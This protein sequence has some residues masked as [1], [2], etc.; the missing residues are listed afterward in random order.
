[1]SVQG[2][3]SIEEVAA[4]FKSQAA[5][6]DVLVAA[7]NMR[8]EH[9]A[10]VAAEAE[11]KVEEVQEVAAEQP[12]EEEKKP[13]KKDPMSAKFAAIARREKEIRARE[14]E[15]ENRAK[16]AEDR[17]AAIKQKEDRF[18]TLKKSP[19]KVLKEEFGLSM[20]DIV[21]DSLGNYKEEEKDPTTQRFE[22][23]EQKLSKLDELEKTIEARFGELRAREQAAAMEQ[24]MD[25]IRETANSGGYEYIQAVGDEAYGLVRDVMKE[26]QIQHKKLL[27]YSEACD[28]VEKHYEESLVEKLLST[29]KAK[30]RY[31]PAE[32]SESSA[33]SKPAKKEVKEPTTLTNQLNASNQATIDI[34]K[35]SRT[36]AIAHL[37]KQ[38]KFNS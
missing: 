22:T 29:Q 1:M 38:L 16:E 10:P 18:Q 11:E 5:G 34:D 14:R 12:V 27:D 6:S 17:I 13:E 31:K 32:K 26:Y 20:A 2:L 24:V 7:Q 23:L 33:P 36:E 9:S 8:D 19:L 35:M 37:S 25:N 15:I 3:P 21:Q 30:S 28:I 4:Q